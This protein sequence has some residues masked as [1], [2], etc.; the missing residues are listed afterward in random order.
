M[1]SRVEGHEPNATVEMG[2]T[3]VIHTHHHEG[4]VFAQ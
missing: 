3:E 1:Q 4:Q 2:S